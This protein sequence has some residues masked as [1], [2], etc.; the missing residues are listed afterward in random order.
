MS[1]RSYS[2]HLA[3]SDSDQEGLEEGYDPSLEG[4]FED[5][6]RYGFQG[7]DM[8]SEETEEEVRE[9]RRDP[10]RF[11]RRDQDNR[12]PRCSSGHRRLTWMIEGLTS[13]VR[14]IV[15]VFRFRGRR[16]TPQPQFQRSWSMATGTERMTAL[17]QARTSVSGP[18]PQQQGAG[19]SQPHRQKPI[20]CFR[21]DQ[22]GHISMHCPTRHFFC[23][24]FRAQ[25]LRD[26]QLVRYGDSVG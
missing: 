20:V 21:C 11:G 9:E 23:L 13:T 1:G 15:D 3:S 4:Q 6:D 10:R 8:D 22:P 24:F 14:E 7:N 17:Q 12:G 16:S 18:C 19:G 5:Y 25:A 2:R 26:P